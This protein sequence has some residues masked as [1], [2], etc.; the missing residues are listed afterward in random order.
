MINYIFNFIP[1]TP[2]VNAIQLDSASQLRVE[3]VDNSTTE[4][5][6]FN[7]PFL[8]D[9]YNRYDELHLKIGNPE[10]TSLLQ[11]GWNKSLNA[12][13]A[14]FKR[15]NYAIIESPIEKSFSDTQAINNENIY[16]GTIG[17]AVKIIEVPPAETLAEWAARIEPRITNLARC[18]ADGIPGQHARFDVLEDRVSSADEVGQ[19]NIGFIRW[20]FEKHANGETGEDNG[21][22]TTKEE[23]EDFLNQ[24]E[25]RFPD[26]DEVTKFYYRHPRT[27][28]A[29]ASTRGQIFIPNEDHDHGDKIHDTFNAHLTGNP[30]RTTTRGKPTPEIQQATEKSE[31]DIRAIKTSF[32]NAA[33]SAQDELIIAREITTEAQVVPEYN[34]DLASLVV[35]TD[36]GALTLQ[37]PF[38]SG[39][40]DGFAADR[41]AYS[42]LVP[43]GKNVIAVVATPEHPSA[44]VVGTG[45][46]TITDRSV[47]T[48]HEVIVTSEDTRN[49]KT[50]T[51]TIIAAE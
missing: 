25:N 30:P 13:W 12:I 21:V 47:V 41:T 46:I 22:Y 20:Q 49:T 33:L 5:M 8:L 32:T 2:Y 18:Y 48:T 34:A 7:F 23:V 4:V 29:A 6:I 39:D 27:K 31:R 16:G 43:T 50:Y 11:I 14:T 40:P 9:M 3:Q 19:L 37:A 51:I 26:K 35:S 24:I 15:S 1:G 38:N 44:T 10:A 42:V 36:V 28:W 45:D 17:A